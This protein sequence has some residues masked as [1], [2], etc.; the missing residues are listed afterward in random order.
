MKY[1]FASTW[2]IA[3]ISILGC[4]LAQA[5]GPVVVGSALIPARNAA[6]VPRT[7]SVLVSFSQPVNPGTAGSISIFSSQYR[8]KRSAIVSTSNSSVTLTPTASAGQSAAFKPGETVS[9]TVP[10]AVLGTSGVGAAPYVYQFTAATTGGSGN[11]TQLANI[12]VSGGG[13][14]ACEVRVGDLDGDGDLDIVTNSG[15]DMFSRTPF[16]KINLLMNNGAGSFTAAAPVVVPRGPS[17]VALGDLDGD[18]D[19]D[20]V[21]ANHGDASGSG[22]T[23]SICFNNGTGSFASPVNL[24]VGQSPQHVKLGDLDNDGDLDLLVDGSP[25]GVFSNNGSGYFTD[26]PVVGVPSGS[27]SRTGSNLADMNGD[28]KLDIIGAGG[29]SQ[30]NGQGNFSLLAGTSGTYFYND[31]VG[32]V[33]GDGDLDIVTVGNGGGLFGNNV[34]VKQNDGMGH[35]STAAVLTVNT[36][37]AA[38]TQVYCVALGDLDGDGD[39]DLA[40]GI[41]NIGVG[42][43]AWQND[44]MGHFTALPTYFGNVQAMNMVPADID[45]DGDLDIV[46]SYYN[47]FYV[48]VLLNNA[49]AL[50]AVVSQAAGKMALYP[51]PSAVGEM[52]WMER[53]SLPVATAVQATIYNTL[54]QVVAVGN[55]LAGQNRTILPTAQLPAGCYNIRLQAPEV[56]LTQRLILN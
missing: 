23:V 55:L 17:S 5:Q 43:A 29:I 34:V 10:A 35:L 8:G 6:S 36:N 41:S 51:N 50:P 18:G 45:G 39:L 26:S 42:V 53:T 22:N 21:S 2:P 25:T 52:V 44:G 40:A 9:V 33:D 1:F 11:F 12:A 24:I 27:I 54:G 3:L 47:G 20:I 7:N 46:A 32:D 13:D 31:V 4:N 37:G 56:N 28:G 15:A 48:S 30:N 16:G 38:F 19:L 49:T 14:W